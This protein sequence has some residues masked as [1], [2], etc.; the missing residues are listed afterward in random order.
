M[1]A[2]NT[3][4]A[5]P[6]DDVMLAMD[7]VDT[8][9]HHRGLVAR[10]LGEADRA[11][12][13]VEKL[14]SIYH[15]QGIEV[16]DHILK[17]GV[18]AL[19]ESRFTYTPSAGG[20]ATTL[21]R[22]YVIRHL[23]AKWVGGAL[24][25]TF[26]VASGYVF[27]YLPFQAGQVEAARIELAE[28]LPAQMDTLYDSIFEETKVQSAV[29]LA[30]QLRQTGKTAALEG[31]RDRAIR[32]VDG[33]TEIRDTIRQDYTL[34]VVNREGVQ[35]GF[36]RFPEVNTAASNY[37]VVVEAI[38]DAGNTL[39]LP[40][41]SEENGQTETVNLWGVRV[42]E[43]I[44]RSVAADKQNDGII[45]RNVVGRKPYGYIE[46][47]YIVPVLGGAVTRW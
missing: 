18:A 4:K 43:R 24:L 15:E 19:D 46:V 14:R 29:V 28:T 30:N 41:T 40:I 33:L 12:Q 20:F 38:D 25:A 27:G 1:T 11:D 47:D 10:E 7:V 23:W 36:W 22:I 21:A 17:E 32:S 16:P 6:L 45:Q 5:L 9:R 35:S 8:L 2:T 34:K 44:Y 42:P 26:I 13:L 3:D 39:A 37:Y 31:D